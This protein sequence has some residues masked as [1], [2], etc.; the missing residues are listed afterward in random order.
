LVTLPRLKDESDRRVNWRQ[1][2]TALGQRVRVDGPPLLDGV[3]TDMLVRS[4]Q[5]ALESGLVEDLDWFEPSRAAVALY[6]L[7]AALPPGPERRDLGRRVYQRVTE[8]TAGTFAA[9]ATRM[10]LGSARA[11][12][13]P[14]LRARVALLFELP[15]GT[16][17]NV[18]VLALAIVMRR[19]TF[20]RWV[21]RA[22]TGP[23]PTRRLAAKLLEHASREAV[24]RTQQADSFP[25][26][27]LL[28]PEVQP[29]LRRLL[30]DREPLV[31]RHAAVAR[32]LLGSIDR[33]TREEIE[34]ALDPGLTPTEWRRA[35]VSL[36]A[37]VA[38]DPQT[39][40]Q[41]C[42][43]L[44]SGE[45][46]QADPGIAAAMVAGLPRVIEAEPDAADSLLEALAATRRP[47]VA[48]AL[49][50]L[51]SDITTRSL[52]TRANQLLRHI[53]IG[54][55]NSN[56]QLTHLTTSHALRV[57]DRDHGDGTLAE[58]IRQA[59]VAYELTG[60]RAA[61]EAA[62]NTASAA[63]GVAEALEAL[64][65]TSTETLAQSLGYLGDLDASC[66]ERS[67][68]LNLLLLSRRPGENDTSVP[69]VERLYHRLGRYLLDAE[70]RC[71][72][73]PA[74][75]E[76]CLAQQRRLRALL[77]LMDAETVQGEADESG[78]RVR[79]RLRRAAKVLTA[80]I[81]AGPDA[82]V[83]R[84]LCATLAR[85]FDAAVR[86]GLV[87]PSELFL[88][89]TRSLTDRESILAVADA[90]TSPDVRGPFL[91]LAQYLGAHVGDAHD[92][93][94]DLPSSPQ[95]ELLVADNALAARRVVR[96]S[97]A[98]GSGGSYR[99][100]A[101]RQVWL[102]LG[103]AL[104]AIGAARGLTEL[105]DRSRSGIDAMRELEQA[106][107]AL[108]ELFHGAE[109]HLNDEERG[110]VEL[111]ITADI[112]PLSVLVE[113]AISDGASPSIEQTSLAITELI[114]DLPE[115]LSSVIAMV[116]RQIE[117]LP[118]AAQSDVYAIPLEKR[119][120]PL[121]DWL[122]PRRTVGAFY[123]VRALG[124]GGVSSVFVLVPH[125]SH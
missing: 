25:R 83:H 21:V 116:A 96:L 82:S 102:R 92:P 68:L 125:C 43:R 118:L 15:I 23:L 80:E 13:P 59:L 72:E 67:S 115:W 22:C 123:V 1:A 90:S 45:I 39:A 41:Q 99:A 84:I 61:H 124:S 94:M 53:L 5:V 86:E 70:Q 27:L 29:V 66:L 109:Q 49:A 74:T 34:T 87:E 24:I 60:A 77:H 37:L 58:G 6:E 38:S 14:S 17:V 78:N 105:V 10:L 8:G 40:L 32:G 26:Q 106:T 103:R 98:I 69:I 30:G 117:V 111:S 81:A 57:L 93:A 52:G 47:D 9:V 46:G 7:S 50:S 100:E 107:S 79:L 35:A 76:T 95:E 28:G 31:W 54:A 119:R 3:R 64:D 112:V 19:E 122:L 44:V 63:H 18:D 2:L 56:N 51:L 113:R 101:L 120:A 104:E 33:A 48:E 88:A 12:D 20:E 11:L 121:P 91:A 73:L 110:S 42:R 75:R 108:R 65:P 36:V 4:V 16:T 85:A 97:Q 71:G 62:L 55:Q 114:A 89:V